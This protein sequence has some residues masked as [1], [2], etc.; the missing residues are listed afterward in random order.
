MD[1]NLK[2]EQEA[3][4]ARANSAVDKVGVEFSGE[5]GDR[6]IDLE[7][8]IHRNNRDEVVSLAYNLESEAAT[9]GW[10]RVTR[11]CK[12]LR[13]IFSGDY[14]EKPQAEVVLE[15]LNALKLMVSDP[16]NPDE[17]RDMELFKKLYPSLEKA[18]H[19]I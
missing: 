11:L 12:W 14:D 16:E 18:V 13:K 8:A 3:M 9:F 19:D 6:V 1:E 5:L 17:E 4:I 10:P 2:K 7:K 15:V